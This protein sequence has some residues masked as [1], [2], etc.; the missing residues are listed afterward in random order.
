ME[1]EAPSSS[2]IEINLFGGG[3]SYGETLLIH[4][5]FS[6][7]IVV[8]SILNPYTNLPVILEYFDKIGEDPKNIILTIASH[9]HDDHIKGIS[10]IFIKSGSKFTISEAISKPFLAK[11]ISIDEFKQTENSGL[12]EFSKIINTSYKLN[13]PLQ[14]AIQDRPLF[15]YVENQITIKV[16]A[17]SP[18]DRAI[19]LFQQEMNEVLNHAYNLNLAFKKNNPND[20]SVV[21]LIEAGDTKVLLGG[22]LE[23]TSDK[24]TGWNQVCN[25]IATPKDCSVEI[26]KIPHHGSINGHHEK[27]WDTILC[28]NHIAILTPYGSGRKKLPSSDDKIRISKMSIESY[29]TSTDLS[30]RK[31]K[32]RDSKVDKILKQFNYKIYERNFDYGHIKLKRELNAQVGQKFNVN[33]YGKASNLKDLKY[34]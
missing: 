3:N 14:R 19:E 22:D 23:I 31:S 24:N 2:Q 9:W 29:I 5:G 30:L 34:E 27:V 1:F 8:D 4:L 28:K 10:E 20:S 25:A 26:F 32:K 17:L 15:S 13:K 7:W 18:S 11:M 33:L 6:K 12:K 16:T 21:L